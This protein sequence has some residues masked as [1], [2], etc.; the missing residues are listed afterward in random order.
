M[1]KSQKPTNF[2]QNKLKLIITITSKLQKQA[3]VTKNNGKQ[4]KEHGN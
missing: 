2:P 1:Y 3:F 4:E